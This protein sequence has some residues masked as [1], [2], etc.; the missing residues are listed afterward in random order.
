MGI[1]LSELEKK[2]GKQIVTSFI[3][4]RKVFAKKFSTFTY[5]MFIYLPMKYEI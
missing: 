2:F 5:E 1:G 4:L 3:K